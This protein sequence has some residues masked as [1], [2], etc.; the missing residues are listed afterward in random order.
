MARP[1]LMKHP[2]FR[3]LVLQLGV[4]TSAARGHLEL[5]WETAYECGDPYIGDETDVALAADWPGDPQVLTAALLTCGGSGRSGFLEPA[6]GRDGYQIHDLYDHAPDYVQKRRMRELARRTRSDGRPP[7]SGQCPD[8]DLTSADNGGQRRTTADDG[9]ST[10]ARSGHTRA[11]APAPAPVEKTPA[12]VVGSSSLEV[13]DVQPVT[14]PDDGETLMVFPCSGKPDSWH[15]VRGAIE[16]LQSAFETVDVMAGCKQALVWINAKPSRRK[17][18]DDMPAFLAAWMAREQDGRPGAPRGEP[19]N[20]KGV[21]PHV[22]LPTKT[23]IHPDDL[24]HQQHPR[25]G[26]F[27]DD[28]LAHDEGGQRAWPRFEA[29]M[30]QHGGAT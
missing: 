13:S 29:W 30:Q 3:R 22:G 7:V 19:G 20:G 28:C 1:G 6:E 5:L 10:R 18:A 15:L 12:V 26:A 8:T 23:P 11:P 14:K 25:F 24:R 16:E 4:R 17:P 21:N 27:V 9:R 2:K